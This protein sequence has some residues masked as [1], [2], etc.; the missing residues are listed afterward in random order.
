MNE[1]M[2]RKPVTAL[3][4]LGSVG[5]PSVNGIGDEALDGE[6]R[7]AGDPGRESCVFPF[8]SARTARGACTSKT[9]GLSL[10]LTALKPGM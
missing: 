3:Y 1:S 4:A 9:T 6:K 2:L 7:G 8:C 5:P 10:S